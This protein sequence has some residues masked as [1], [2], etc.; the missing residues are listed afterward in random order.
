MELRELE[1]F[2]ARVRA[3]GDLRTML[4]NLTCSVADEG[5][6]QSPLRVIDP[7]DG[8]WL[9]ALAGLWQVVKVGVQYLRGLSEMQVLEKRLEIIRC[10][11]PCASTA[12]P[13]HRVEEKHND[14]R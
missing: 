6:R 4:E 3:D 12:L 14:V 13:G 1:V 8:L 2:E 11:R 10:K 7:T 9:V 5:E